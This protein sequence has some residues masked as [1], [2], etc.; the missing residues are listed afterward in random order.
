[1]ESFWSQQTS[2]T[3]VNKTIGS[4]FNSIYIETLLTINL[5]PLDQSKTDIQNTFNYAISEQCQ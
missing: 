3:Q 5:E 1:M 4:H 2:F